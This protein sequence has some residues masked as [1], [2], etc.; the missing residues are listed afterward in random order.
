MDETKVSVRKRKPHR[1]LSFLICAV[2]VLL[3]SAGLVNVANAAINPG[4]GLAYPCSNCGS[5]MTQQYKAPTCTTAGGSYWRC[6]NCSYTEG[7][8][9]EPALGHS[10]DNDCDAS[11]NRCGQTRSASHSYSYTANGETCYGV[12]SVCGSTTGTGHNKTTT[13][14]GATC[15]QMS[16]TVTTCSRCD[17]ESTSYTGTAPLGHIYQDDGN[18]T[19]AVKCTRST[20]GCGYS[21]VISAKSSHSYSYACDTSC[22][23]YGCTQTRTASHGNWYYRA[24]Q[25]TNTDDDCVQIC[26]YCDVEYDSDRHSLEYD[27]NTCTTAPRC[28]NC[29]TRIGTGYTSHLASADDGNCLTPVT[30]SRVG[31]GCTQ[32]V[33]AAKSQ[34]SY[35]FTCD[36]TC[37]N[38][39]CT[40]GNRDASHGNW[41]Y[42]SIHG[43]S[44][45]CVWTCGKCNGNGE[46]NNGSAVQ[47]KDH[48]LEA[49]DYNCTTARACKNCGFV[50]TAAFGS[51]SYTE[52][53][54]DADYTC[55]RNGCNYERP[56]STVTVYWN[57]A[58]NTTSDIVSATAAV[59]YSLTIPMNPTK[60]G[61]VFTGFVHS[62][63]GSFNPNTG[64][65]V[66]GETNATLSAQW[67]ANTTL[68]IDPCGGTYNGETTIEMGKGQTVTV[69]NPTREGYTF[70]GWYHNGGGSLSGST[71][72]FGDSDATLSAQWKANSSSGTAVLVGVWQ[73]GNNLDKWKYTTETI[74]SSTEQRSAA[75]SFTSNGSRFG[76]MSWEYTVS[77][78]VSS[79]L[80][81]GGTTVF[82]ELYGEGIISRD[83]ATS[84]YQLVDFGT[85][86][87]TVSA[88]FYNWLS[89]NASPVYATYTVNHHFQNGAGEFSDTNLRTQVLSAQAGTQVTPVFWDE[90]AAPTEGYKHSDLWQVPSTQ[91][92]TVKADGSTVVD[93]YY[94]NK[95]YYIVLDGNG[96]TSGS[97][98]EMKMRINATDAI[99]AVTFKKTGFVFAGWNTKE[100]GTGI[101]YPD[102]ATVGPAWSMT[103]G[104]RI[105]LY[106]MWNE[107]TKYT[108]TWVNNGE[109]LET[110]TVGAGTTATYNGATPTKDEDAQYTY[111]FAGWDT[112]SDGE[113]DFAGYTTPVV[114]SDLTCVAVFDKTV[115]QYTITW[116]NWDGTVLETDKVNYGDTPVYNG[117]TPT[118]PE[119][120]SY[121]YTFAGWE[122]S[123]IPVTG[124]ATYQ[125][126]F[127]SAPKKYTVTLNEGTGIDRVSG[128]GTYSV[129]D[130][131]TVTATVST[132]YRWSGWTGYK[133]SSNITFTF[134]MPAQN[135]TLTANATKISDITITWKD[136]DGEILEVDSNVVYGTTPSYDG[137]TPTRAADAQYTY[138]FSGW[139][140]A[141]SAATGDV[142]YTATYSKVTNKYTVTW[143]NWDGTVLETDANVAYGTTPTYNGATPARE[144]S[145]QYTYT[146]SGWSPTVSPVTGDVVY[147]AQFTSSAVGYTIT[148]KNWDGTVLETDTN[149]AYGATP[150]YNGATPTKPET[151]TVTYTF[152]GWDP[153]VN[154]VT[155]DCTYTAVFLEN[156]KDV[157][158]CEHDYVLE[159]ETLPTCTTAGT[160]FYKCSKCDNR[161]AEEGQPATGHNMQVSNR[162]EPTCEATGSET[163]TCQN[164]CGL[165]ETVTLTA[166]G[167]VPGAAAT[168]T[169]AQVCT[170]SGCGKELNPALGH[171]WVDEVVDSTSCLVVG[172]IK[173][174]C[175]RPGCGETKTIST[176]VGP[177]KPDRDAPTCTE[178]QVC[179]VCGNVLAERTGHSPVYPVGGGTELVH[180]VCGNAGCGIV[181]NA[182]HSFSQSVVTAAG[183]STAGKMLNQCA[184][185]YSYESTIPATGNHT[186]DRENAT[187][188][189]AK[190]CTNCDYVFEPAL[191][192]AFS[193][194]TC[195]QPEKCTR[196]GCDATGAPALGHEYTSEIITEPTV[197]TTG[198]RRYTCIRC[199]HTYDET[200]PMLNS[201]GMMPNPQRPG[202]IFEGWFTQPNGQGEKLDYIDLSMVGDLTVYAH[203]TPIVYS[204]TYKDHTGAVIQSL[205]YTIEDAVT[206]NA[207]YT[208]TGYAFTTWLMEGE[209]GN[210]EVCEYAAGQSFVAGK[211]GNI[212]LTTQWE[213]I[214]YDVKYDA[215]GGTGTMANTQHTYDV[216]SALRKN[217]FSKVGYAFLGWATSAARANAGTVD[218]A[219]Q[220][221]VLNLASTQGA[222]VTL[223]AVWS[224]CPH[225]WQVVQTVPPTCLTDGYTDYECSKCGDTKRVVDTGSALG[226]DFADATCTAPQTCTR[227]GA[228]SGLPLGHDYVGTVTVK[229]TATTT[230][231]KT[232]VCS[233][234][235][236]TYTEV[237]AAG[238]WLPTP[239]RP[240]Y[241]FMGWFTEPDGEGVKIEF[242][243]PDDVLGDLDLHAYWVPIVYTITYMVDGS[244][245]Q[246]VN[247]TI[248][249]AITLPAFGYTGKTCTWIQAEETGNWEVTGYAEGQSFVAGLYGDVTLTAEWDVS[250]FTITW[251]NWDGTILEVDENVPYGSVPV[252]NG[253]IP[254]K[255][256]PAGYTWTFDHWLPTVS[257]VTGDAT[258]VAQFA[259]TANTV[260]I[261]LDPNGGSGGTSSVNATYDADLPKI[262][263]PTRQGYIFLGYFSGTSTAPGTMYYDADGN[264]VRKSDFI[265]ATTLYAQWEPISYQVKYNANGGSGTMS[266]STHVYDVAKA[267]NKNTFSRTGYTFAGWAETPDGVVKYSDQ[268]SVKNLSYTDGAVVDLYAVWTPNIYTITYKNGIDGTTLS[269]QT[270]ALA[271]AFA[272]ASAPSRM[273]YAFDGWKVTTA[274]GSWTINSTYAAAKSFSAGTMYGD[275]T[276]TALWTPDSYK[277]TYNE[278]GGYAVADLSYT[279]ETDITLATAPT[280]EGYIFLGWSLASSAGNWNIGLYDAGS[281]VGTGKYGNIELVA[282]WRAITY[283]VK[284]NANGGVGVMANSNHVYD[285]AK[286][287]PKNIFTREGYTFVG[288]ATSANGGKVYSDEQAVLNIATSDGAVVELYAVWTPWSYTVIYHG[289]GSTSG[290][291]P[292]S[293]HYRD[294]AQML[295]A[296]GF[297]KQ[298][299]VTFNANGGTCATNSLTAKYNFYG[300]ALTAT[301]AKVYDDQQ[302]VVNL[303][304]VPGSTVNL[305][306]VWT[307]G[308]ITLPTPTRTGYIFAGWALSVGDTSVV[309]E[310]G[311]TYTAKA[312]VTLYALWT[313][314]TYY[315]R[316]NANGGV[317][318]M[319]ISTFEYGRTYN[320]AKN[321]FTRAG[322]TFK[323]WA[324]SANGDKVYNDRQ[325]VSD[326]ATT[327]GA[328]V[329]LYAVWETNTYSIVYDLVG[330]TAGAN[331]PTEA[332]Y[333][334]GFNVSAP[335]RSGYIFLGWKVTGMDNT[336]HF[337]GA[338]STNYSQTTESTISR[339]TAV[340][341]KN[342]TAVAD[343]TVQFAAVWASTDIELTAITLKYYDSNGNLRTIT[344]LNNVPMVS[345][346]YVYHTYTNNSG[347][348]QTVNGYHNG[349]SGMITY[350]GTTDFTLAAGASMQVLAGNFVPA[351]GENTITGY[352]Y[353]DGKPFGDTSAENDGTNN[354]K[355]LTYRVAFD[356]ELVEIYFT[357]MN[358][359]RLDSDNILVGVQ[360]QVHHIYRNNSAGAISVDFYHNGVKYGSIA[361]MGANSTQDVVA[362]TFT[363]SAAGTYS[364][365]G[366]IYRS[367]MNASTET[368]EIDLVNN[369]ELLVYEAVNGPGLDVFDPGADL[370]MGTDVF[371]SLTITNDNDTDFTPDNPLL[372]TVTITAADGTLV[373]KMTQEAIVPARE[374]QLVW[375]RWTVPFKEGPYTIKATI[376]M[377]EPGDGYTVVVDEFSFTADVIGRDDVFPPE[378][379]YED[380]RPSDWAQPAKP[381]TVK[382]SAE[383]TVWEYD[384]TNRAFKQVT[385]GISVSP[386]TA[387]ITP[388]S[389]TAYK[390]GG[391]WYMKAGYGFFISVSDAHINSAAGCMMPNSRDYTTSQWSYALFPEFKYMTKQSGVDYMATMEY[392]DG[393][394][395][396]ADHDDYGRKHFTPVWYPD[397][398]APADA[399]FVRLVQT[400]I[401]TPVGVLTVYGPST[402]IYISGD[403]YDD[404][405]TS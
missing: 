385:Y 223:Y 180:Q 400:E 189:E 390:D 164:G 122:P 157:V 57:G 364:V 59:G 238:I 191:G 360:V 108:V 161:K 224:T 163:T 296:N 388:D 5:S 314:I 357:D 335:T 243:E 187:C 186:P 325:A 64:V 84:A 318:S 256:T 46:Y 375:F 193:A 401:W 268:A 34:H 52:K 150:A 272:L 26:G 255:T 373:K 28:K 270:Y 182:D 306:A 405:Y 398:T 384:Y 3:C 29:E 58:D 332:T 18:C 92:V 70:N 188:T 160:L 128:G 316:Y 358:G 72:T 338:S 393:E 321:T 22:N 168:C 297:A 148:W 355:S 82:G 293:T 389:P 228:T 100:D 185:G 158:A 307:G 65:L 284:Y 258:Y 178:D 145:T 32:V 138:T 317:G 236:D 56:H 96:A 218:Y 94:Y 95:Y 196:N 184:C 267:L 301:G 9:T 260:T 133:T 330:G 103:N 283:Q 116:I 137:E 41:K 40:E 240:G 42:S 326:L 366:A 277:I 225:D 38:G 204:I 74:F 253:A 134:E 114:T 14:Y 201:G 177:H 44:G 313:P 274:S 217:T 395:V 368:C 102:C 305:Y 264:G 249:D 315:V 327:Q 71:F 209:S 279:I 97:M 60:S 288:W 234:C 386:G 105:Y 339:T 89:V 244:V 241:I 221:S 155:G 192:H 281:N 69:S 380:S 351:L 195:T 250:T 227:C 143:K 6:G 379:N 151:A 86:R 123:V 282:Q 359:N 248:E 183:C 165:T 399:Y 391:Q 149:V 361:N 17:Y 298:Y 126:V 285:V 172:Y 7:G 403:I 111:T 140:P 312:D 349:S 120:A 166:L 36:A 142:T 378:T 31:A 340:W 54:T 117:A 19:T 213:P 402:G 174:T 261:T 144:G 323:G 199:D 276:L 309:G 88:D 280:R 292:N 242:L 208:R 275:V 207:A 235:G 15:T 153:V 319:G 203:W 62:G 141:V 290:S 68:T 381:S 115:K 365:S 48:I 291:T 304:T 76:S 347:L 113:P 367:G 119:D 220:A 118:K 130:N 21:I 125:A 222:T 287:L 66:W 322:Y 273:G 342:L 363:P 232:Y 77:S 246:T 124:D 91:T 333:D 110:D 176:T 302:S 310:G 4:I 343:G 219:D 216:A 190:K 252:Y 20:N 147:T 136:W 198:V 254:T 345:R 109:I 266:N 295:N 346:V 329:D 53:P 231:I 13:S 87:Q 226:H 265:S 311:D 75:V 331:A 237:L 397:T 212:T 382:D 99:R 50:V 146:F 202:Y 43:G 135:V 354:S 107:D 25:G 162:V 156:K 49:D 179:T 392:I 341:F 286:N 129:G 233:R 205:N 337:H 344:D 352:V 303:T 214:T 45:G 112:N 200:I 206:L 24:R 63:G 169:T 104:E 353:L 83:W 37:N 39:S 396:F 55:D 170:R 215:N 35:S 73:F 362:A 171:D 377:T 308:T 404:W 10:W 289:N 387:V 299:T 61:Y 2:F 356:V 173:S 336:T 154:A 167:H 251:K 320:L 245:Y 159:S 131:V 278:N 262:T 247:Y 369:T 324:T 269:T 132:G 90:I 383:W 139:T 67:V 33:V 23:N 47:Y 30:C 328:I 78:V 106:A 152:Y 93:Y 239:E 11:C 80:K 376:E 211:Y 1:G 101:T 257:P 98:P 271:D 175:V 194:A 79:S 371:T 259:S 350:S 81:Y 370:R 27:D 197:T 121:T 51:H 229:P 181:L 127:N 348:T 210:W 394:W 8:G 85:G 230:G 16:R 263:A 372:V 294:Q 12:C 300:W 374:E 334:V